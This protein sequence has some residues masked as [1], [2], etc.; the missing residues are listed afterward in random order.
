MVFKLVVGV[1]GLGIV[2]TNQSF[3]FTNLINCFSQKKL[4]I[5]SMRVADNPNGLN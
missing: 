5:H 4:I 3:V 1:G 2:L